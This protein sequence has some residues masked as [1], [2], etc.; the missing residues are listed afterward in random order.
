VSKQSL[1]IGV[2][3][4]AIVAAAVVAYAF[5]GSDRYETEAAIEVTPVRADDETFA[6]FSVL[7]AGQDPVETA[8]QLVETRPVADAV[9]VRLRLT[10]GEEAL[11]RVDARA[12]SRGRV[13][14]IRAHARR[15]IEAAR[16]ANAFADELIRQRSSLFQSELQRT[17]GS[18][19]AQLAGVP[20]SRRDDPPAADAAR[21]LAELRAHEGRGDPTLRVAATATAPREP[22]S[23]QRVRILALG[24]PLAVVLGAAAFLAAGRPSW[25]APRSPY[26]DARRRDEPEPTPPP[27]AVESPDTSVPVAVGAPGAFT[28]ARLDSVLRDHSDELP[29][30]RLQ[31]LRSY[32]EF[33]RPYAN[34]DGTLPKSFDPLVD[35]VF[36]DLLGRS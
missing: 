20:A 14:R 24:L 2:A 10:N 23:P 11:A 31:E 5:A 3:V 8:A 35:E 7:R 25:R 33:L 34:L 16:I 17:I 6:G 9:A 32:L 36:G 29:P 21:R 19:R 26:P 30:E 28:L 15:A 1:A 12:E 13:V 4:T 22:A 18:L 27:A